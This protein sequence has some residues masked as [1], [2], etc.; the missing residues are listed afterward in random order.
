MG[1]VAEKSH[2][3]EEIQQPED[4]KKDNECALIMFLYTSFT[5]SVCDSSESEWI[6]FMQPCLGHILKTCLGH[7]LAKQKKKEKGYFA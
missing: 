3:C 4:G 2:T 1:K 7:T 6:C 5:G